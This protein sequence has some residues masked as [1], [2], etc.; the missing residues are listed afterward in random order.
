MLDF[1]DEKSPV[2]RAIVKVRN[3]LKALNDLLSK[4]STPFFYDQPE[5]TIA[6]Y[7][8]FEAYTLSRD[9]HEKMI[10]DEVNRQALIQLEQVMKERPSLAAYFQRGGLIERFTGSPTEKD[11]IQKLRAADSS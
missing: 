5:P 4:S 2:S 11:Y 9:Y 8:V 10:P 7:F 1:K 6:D 3:D